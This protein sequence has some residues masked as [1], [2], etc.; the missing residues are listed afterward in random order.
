MVPLKPLA[1]AQTGQPFYNGRATTNFWANHVINAFMGVKGVN[2]HHWF[3]RAQHGL[4]A[5][6]L[7][8]VDAH[9]WVANSPKRDGRAEF[10]NTS[11]YRL[12]SVSPQPAC[13]NSWTAFARDLCTRRF[14]TPDHQTAEE[15]SISRESYLSP[16]C[17]YLQCVS[18]DIPS[19]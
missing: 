10:A 14:T 3:S 19:L 1:E 6:S 8:L 17:V 11:V 18:L 16:T 9:S 2:H 5:L 4:R 15:H 7:V 12:G 13:A